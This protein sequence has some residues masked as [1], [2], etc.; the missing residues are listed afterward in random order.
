MKFDDLIA[1]VFDRDKKYEENT[2]NA[3]DVL[4]KKFEQPLRGFKFPPRA[5]MCFEGMSC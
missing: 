1:Q 5:Y 3:L 4:E 2:K